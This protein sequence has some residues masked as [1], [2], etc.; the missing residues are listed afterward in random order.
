MTDTTGQKP[1][2][3]EFE[4]YRAPRNQWWDVWDQF[5]THKGALIG[6]AFFIFVLLFVFMTMFSLLGM[7]IFGGGDGFAGQRKNVILSKLARLILIRQQLMLWLRSSQPKTKPLLRPM[8][9]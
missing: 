5:K 7:Q 8:S 6:A 2:A 1:Q 3:M 9:G 4:T